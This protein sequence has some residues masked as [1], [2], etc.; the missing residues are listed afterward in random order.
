MRNNEWLV[1]KLNLIW[2][3]F[4]PDI[5]RKNKVSIKFGRKSK[6]K[7]GH[8]TMRKEETKIVINKFFSYEEVPE[9]ILDLTIAHELVHYAHG[10]HSPH[11]RMFNHPHKGGVVNKELVTRGLGSLIK[12][13]RE[14]VKEEW[15]RIYPKLSSRF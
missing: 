13:E 2:G 12:K 6:S 4:F 3:G 8:I 14:W 1:D 5:D 11:K 10:F 7:F 9:Y 15:P